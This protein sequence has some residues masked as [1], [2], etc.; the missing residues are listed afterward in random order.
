M[1]RCYSNSLLLYLAT[2]FD[3]CR[4]CLTCM[5]NEFIA[6]VRYV[7]KL[8]PLCSH[9]SEYAR[10]ICLIALIVYNYVLRVHYTVTQ[11]TWRPAWID[12]RDVM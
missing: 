2:D 11:S 6:L 8:G 1:R 5:V 10:L 9:V 7:N 12:D 3:N 4:T